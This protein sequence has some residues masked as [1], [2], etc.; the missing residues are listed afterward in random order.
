M[1]LLS[2]RRE[3]AAVQQYSDLAYLRHQS[4]GCGAIERSLMRS[5]GGAA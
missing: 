5:R 3:G 1:R 2:R 4:R